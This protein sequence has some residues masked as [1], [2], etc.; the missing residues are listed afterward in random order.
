MPKI[1]GIS[2][3]VLLISNVLSYAG[4]EMNSI[5]VNQMENPK[6]EYPKSLILAFGLIL[7]VF[8]IPTLAIAVAVPKDQIG[9]TDGLFV[10]FKLFFDTLNVGFLSNVI[11]ILILFG[12][13][14]S[15]VTWVSGPSR[16]L[17]SAAKKGLLPPVFQKENKNHIQS[18]ILIP[19]G[20]IVTLLSLIYVFVPNVSDVFLAMVGMAAALYI[21]MYLMMFVSAVILRKKDPGAHRTFKVPCLK[22]FSTVG[23]I[24]CILSLVMSFVPPTGES[25]IPIAIYPVVVL[26]VVVVLGV[27]PLI[28]Y[29]IK[30]KS[31]VSA[32]SD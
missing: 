30:K 22:L 13:L 27:P 31:W 14:A 21:I 19:Q 20:I 17:F 9:M 5:H 18:G 3:F 1:T 10:A 26:V 4:M 12:A 16:G 2:S 6:K 29:S 8:I 25:A 11:S 7:G 23:F 28:F 15:I 32:S 24:A